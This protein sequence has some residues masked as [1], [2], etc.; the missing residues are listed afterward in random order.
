M[1][2]ARTIAGTDP[3]SCGQWDHHAGRRRLRVVGAFHLVQ[4]RREVPR[5]EACPIAI[6]MMEPVEK[7][8]EAAG[9]GQGKNA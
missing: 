7:A 4:D 5:V 2:R 8:P 9:D 6:P 1:Y 3:M